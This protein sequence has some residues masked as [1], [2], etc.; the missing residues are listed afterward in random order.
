MITF[1]VKPQYVNVINKF[2]ELIKSD[3]DIAKLQTSHRKDAIFS[4]GVIY[5]MHQYNISHLSK[6]GN[7]KVNK[8]EEL[9]LDVK[10]DDEEQ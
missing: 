4:V 1:Y 8:E 2:M 7:T 9:Q 10:E 3:S 5:A 6:T